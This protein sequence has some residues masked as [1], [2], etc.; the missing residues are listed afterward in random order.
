MVGIICKKGILQGQTVSGFTSVLDGMVAEILYGS[1]KRK[2]RRRIM[3][4]ESPAAGGDSAERL[5]R[6]QKEPM[7]WKR[8][9][10][11]TM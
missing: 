5:E 6:E 4:I 1:R 3:D 10:I 8:N 7:P 9:P 2:S 11:L